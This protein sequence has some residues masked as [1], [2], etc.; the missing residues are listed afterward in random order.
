MEPS[1]R[2]ARCSPFWLSRP[3]RPRSCCRAACA[4]TAVVFRMAPP[5][6]KRRRALYFALPPCHH[7]LCAISFCGDNGCEVW[8]DRSIRMCLF[9]V[10]TII[11]KVFS[12]GA[13]SY[14]R[15]VDG[16]GPLSGHRAS[17]GRHG[18]A[19]PHVFDSDSQFRNRESTSGAPSPSF[20]HM[21]QS[22]TSLPHMFSIPI[23]D[24]GIE[25]RVCMTLSQARPF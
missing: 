13:L 11:M 5:R 18:T 23:L 24:S 15:L 25:N 19:S 16:H 14:V 21:I 20:P 4:S 2:D 12:A 8:I 22:I 6:Q 7:A 3:P 10:V 9:C 1:A 17:H